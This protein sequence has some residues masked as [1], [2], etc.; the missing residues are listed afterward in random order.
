MFNF[1]STASL[2]FGNETAVK[3]SDQILNLLGKNIFV[4]TDEGLTE[5]GLYD[6]TIKKLQ[7]KS[8]INIFNKVESDPSKSTLLKAFEEATDFKS[9]GVLGFG[10]GSSMDVAKLI[11]LLLGSNQNIDT[12]WGV[13]NAKGPRIP[14]VLI[15]TT[16]GTGS[17][18]T[19]ISIITMDDKEKKGVSSKLILP[20]LAIL[21]PSL[22]INLPQN[23]TASTG[24]DAMVHAIE[25][26]TSINPNNNPI[27]KMLS[28]E[29]LKFLGSSIK[30]AVFEGHNINARSNMLFGSML[31]GKA[32]ANSPVAAVH[33]LAY[34]IGGLFNISHGLSNS[35]VL[36]SV[37]KFN[38]INKETKKNYV[39]LAPFVF[40]DLDNSKSD[41]IVCNNFIDSL[42]SLSKELKLP[43]RLRDLEIPE[44]ACQLMASEAMK[45]TRLLV[46]NPRKIEE[47]D[48]YNIYNLFGRFCLLIN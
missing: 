44:E 6:K 25:A 30:T 40:K 9:T 3:S 2:I 18:V 24:I 39:H 19:P 10:G 5:L 7:S 22:T 29:A 28:I 23:I 32:F 13:N 46:N 34:P 15:P 12:I 42:E 20:D 41:E 17:E 26:Y 4:I 38:S 35:L 16:A 8:N 45:Q 27:S 1:H 31:A 36:P 48:A 37:M 33:A 43:Y 14:L 47:S 21:D 11:S